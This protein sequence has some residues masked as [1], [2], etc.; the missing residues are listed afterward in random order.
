MRQL[1]EAVAGDPEVRIFDLTA[2]YCDGARCDVIR[3]GRLFFYD[4]QHLTL[5]GGRAIS[6][7]LEAMTDWL[8]AKSPS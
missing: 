4:N 1:R 7:S 6:P 2:H 5:A 8:L 3:D